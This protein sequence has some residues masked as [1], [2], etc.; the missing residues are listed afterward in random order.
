MP[1]GEGPNFHGILNLF[2]KKAHLFKKGTKTGEYTVKV[3]LHREVTLE[4][5]VTVTAEGGEESSAAE[6]KGRKKK[7]DAAVEAPAAEGAAE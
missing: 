1:I 4:V 3:K 7:E 2:D 6:M 5:P